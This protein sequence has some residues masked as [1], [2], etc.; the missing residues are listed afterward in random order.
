MSHFLSFLSCYAKMQ[1]LFLVAYRSKPSL[2][3]DRE[4]C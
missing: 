3:L 4:I 1:M 2:E